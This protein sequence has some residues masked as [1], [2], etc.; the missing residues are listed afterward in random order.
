VASNIEPKLQREVSAIFQ[1]TT[2]RQSGLRGGASA[3]R[4]DLAELDALGF[5]DAVSSLQGL[6]LSWLTQTDV[7]SH[8]P[9]M[10]SPGEEA[11]APAAAKVRKQRT[12][13]SLPM[14]PPAAIVEE[15]DEGG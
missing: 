11:R 15:R 2:A 7:P 4:P 8:S 14:A 5:G 3:R 1:G 13:R 6:P 10:A 12:S 9:R